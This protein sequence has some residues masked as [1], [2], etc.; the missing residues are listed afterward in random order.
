MIG[1]IK[2][3]TV[4]KTADTQINKYVLRMCCREDKRYVNVTVYFSPINK[5]LLVAGFCKCSFWPGAGSMPS[6][7]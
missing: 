5:G 7:S 1:F 6:K 2:K 4:K 3:A